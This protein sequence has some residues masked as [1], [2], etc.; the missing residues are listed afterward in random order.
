MKA[1]LVILIA[2]YIMNLRATGLFCRRRNNVIRILCPAG[3]TQ[4]NSE[5]VCRRTGT[6]DFRGHS[7]R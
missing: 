4:R 6:T 2:N 5:L 7:M 1:Y 3:G